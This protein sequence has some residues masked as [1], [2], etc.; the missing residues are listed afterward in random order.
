MAD[1]LLE[2]GLEEVPARM[3]AGAQAEL[4]RRTLALLGKE[5]LLP[6]GFDPLTGAQSYSTPRRLTVLVRGVCEQQSDIT[7]DVTGP[8]VKIAFKD[9]VP[10][11]AAEAF[12]R[13][14]GVAVADLRTISTPKGEYLA[15]TSVKKGS[16]AAEVIVG[17]MPKEIAAIY[18]AKNMYWRP[19]KPERFVRPVLWMVCLLGDD[20]V[21]LEFAGKTA[22][23]ETYGHRVLA[24]DAAIEIESPGSY[25]TQLAQAHVCADVEV[26]RHRIRKALDH[27]TRKAS[28]KHAVAHYLTNP[29]NRSRCRPT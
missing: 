18:W 4:L 6:E 25:V 23:R 26:R 13:R 24:G 15:A 2:I 22:A 16:S 20:V 14:S 29:E 9:G 7:E 28:P 10:T 12:A 5:K 1:F 21:P 19:G 3:I 17:E 11:P 27:V 8:A